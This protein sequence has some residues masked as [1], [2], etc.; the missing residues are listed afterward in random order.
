MKQK[1]LLS[2]LMVMLT[3]FAV[4][5]QDEMKFT[6]PPII[7]V[8][9]YGDYVIFTF[10]CEEDVNELNVSF[11]VNG[12][13]F[14]FREGYFPWGREANYTSSDYWMNRTYE[15]QNVEII[16]VA[17]A[18][19]KEY[20]EP[21]Q[22]IYTITPLPVTE[23]TS[24][25][26][27]EERRD[28]EYYDWSNVR[29]FNY[30]AYAFGNTDESDVVMYYRYHYTKDWDGSEV[31]SDW[32]TTYPMM[33]DYGGTVIVDPDL[34]INENAYG[35]VE[36]YAKAENKYESDTVRLE[37][38]VDCYPSIHFKRDYDFYV[39]GIYYRIIDD[40]SVAVSKHTID[41]TVVFD[42]FEGTIVLD[43]SWENWEADWASG[44]I[45]IWGSMNPCYYG[46]VVIPSTVDYKGKTYTVT[47][48]KDYAFEG[49]ELTSIQLPSTITSIG[50]C[51]FYASAIP[52]LML[53]DSVDSIGAG[54]FSQCYYLT[55]VTIPESITS[56]GDG[57]FSRCDNLAS[58]SIPETVTRIG[59]GAFA[60]CGN[61]TEINI[62]NNVTQI[63]DVAF[64][65]CVSLTSI[66]IPGTVTLIGGF[67]FS[68]CIGLKTIMCK[69]IVPPDAY[70]AF[71]M[72]DYYLSLEYNIYDQA[73]L[74]VPNESI[75][76][77]RAHEEWGRFSHIVPF[78]GAGPG[79]V[80][81]DGSIGIKD[82]TDLVDQLLSDG[83]VP[84]W[85]DV[86]GDGNVGIK[87]ITDLI[88]RL[89][90]ED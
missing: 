55:N 26:I 3:G 40:T 78:I 74:F 67:A 30:F 37:F 76:E 46:D 41:E 77:Y 5:A 43:P 14:D 29:Y 62:P 57:A 6:D 22:F 44:E 38:F 33:P 49:C 75:E 87:D 68:D 51:A 23:K 72:L 63:G 17:G 28:P 9:D 18:E 79:D 88:D 20:S 15:E 56:I 66:D 11:Y 73:T 34:V 61:L 89:L 59:I 80:N 86:N 7:S 85:M 39:D 83:D 70:D 2:L 12:E 81:G 8:E 45:G 84:A 36:L 54:T 58:V 64:A 90:S 53:S 82:A 35:W 50:V 13:L 27:I 71:Y 52:D 69:A 1:L 4:A 24:T 21:V 25:P 10:T 60:Y 31:S 32:K 16:A 47:A 48:V 42:P 65:H 19:G